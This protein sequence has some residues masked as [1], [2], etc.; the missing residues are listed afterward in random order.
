MVTSILL[1]KANASAFSLTEFAPDAD[2]IRKG[3]KID[4]ENKKPPNPIVSRVSAV[5]LMLQKEI[6]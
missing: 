4:E 6:V 2:K 1:R 5:L 3:R